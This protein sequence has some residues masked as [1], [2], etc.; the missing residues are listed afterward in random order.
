ILTSDEDILNCGGQIRPVLREIGE[1][2]RPPWRYRI[3]DPAAAIHS[4]APRFERS[5]TLKPVQHRI[6]HSFADRDHG[7]G[8]FT[9]GLHDL[10]AVHLLLAQEPENEELRNSVHEIRISLPER[11]GNNIPCGSMYCN[12]LVVIMGLRM[13]RNQ[14]G[15]QI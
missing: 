12:S 5:I 7:S 15:S 6:Y 8:A 3:I 10:V 9:D 4:F 1:A 11:H 13:G 2:S 14:I